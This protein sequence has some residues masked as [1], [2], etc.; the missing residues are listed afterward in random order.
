MSFGIGR[1]LLHSYQDPI[2]S[3]RPSAV[4][5]QVTFLDQKQKADC[6]PQSWNSQDAHYA[7]ALSL[8]PGPGGG[9]RAASNSAG[10]NG[11][12]ILPKSERNR[13]SWLDARRQRRI[14]ANASMLPAVVVVLPKF[15][16]TSTA[17]LFCLR[18]SCGK[19]ILSVPGLIA[20]AAGG[21]SCRPL[22]QSRSGDVSR[23]GC[24]IEARAGTRK[25]PGRGM[26][27]DEDEK[28]VSEYSGVGT[29]RLHARWPAAA[30]A[31][32]L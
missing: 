9:R 18:Q 20:L 14:P 1:Y 12:A 15:C 19:M 10:A 8:L 11:G 21:G 22:Q 16:R 32:E 24:G 5:F 31:M 3:Y 7:Q 13:R 25:A 17:F 6:T 26:E 4:P 27:C 30:R 2:F 23:G 28:A 29:R